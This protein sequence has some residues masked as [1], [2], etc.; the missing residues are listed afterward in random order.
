MT[1]LDTRRRPK[2]VRPNVLILE[3]LFSDLQNIVKAAGG[4]ATEASPW[5]YYDVQNELLSGN[6]HAMILTGGSDVNPEM[7]TTD[8]R[9]PEVYG[10][11]AQRDRVETMALE[12]AAQ[13]GIPVLG[14]CRGSQIMAAFRGG[15]LVQHIGEDHRGTSHEV[16][17]S[18][19][20]RT[21]RRA[22][23]GSECDVISLH[24]Q[25]ILDPGKGMRFS[26]FAYD[27]IT[28]AI[29][30]NDGKWLGC[31]F[32]PEMDAFE[33]LTSFSIF[34]WLIAEAARFAGGRA[35]R[36]PFRGARA[37]GRMASWEYAENT[38]QHSY[39][40]GTSTGEPIA[41]LESGSSGGPDRYTFASEA[42]AE[43]DYQARKAAGKVSTYKPTRQRRQAGDRAIP[44]M[45]EYASGLD[46]M[47]DLVRQSI[48]S[49]AYEMAHSGVDELH[50]CPHC[51]ILFD[52]EA[53][54]ND[55]VIYVHGD[56]DYL[57]GTEFD[58]F[59][60]LH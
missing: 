15:Q 28:E 6:Y 20:G 32:H 55:H 4:H 56:S 49:T 35:P 24:H 43:A 30:S 21:F 8:K 58:T 7:Y 18:A 17:A 42:E 26:G 14:I 47:A 9:H 2:V 12:L 36:A 23:N 33:S 37:R 51:S 46:E 10:V 48:S 13:Q 41:L 39:L 57:I 29:E 50:T 40:G 31:Q 27:G 52:D 11:D 19:Q 45:R 54:R 22:I 5:D 59:P 60:Y 34:R 1:K 25:C 38:V 16:W 44:S 3:G 53:D